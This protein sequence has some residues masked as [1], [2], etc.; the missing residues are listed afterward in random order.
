MTWLMRGLFIG[1]GSVSVVLGVIGMV[2]PLLPTTPFLLLAAYCFLKS[3]DRL[4]N[5]LIH[6]KGIGPYIQN[7]RSGKGI[8]VKT[9]IIALLVL[10]TSASFS[11]L[12]FVPLFIV[13]AL[14]F[15]IVGIVTYYILSLKTYR[16]N[17]KS[18]KNSSNKSPTVSSS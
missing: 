18:S 5:K 6:S 4:Y 3:S 17:V 9:K 2:L 13:Q 11:I 10:W 7:Y 16:P 12:F 14:L 8:P 1:V 15:L